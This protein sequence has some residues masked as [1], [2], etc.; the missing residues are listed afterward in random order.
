M[1][2][3]SELRSEILDGLGLDAAT[4]APFS[5]DLEQW[6]S[7]LAVDQPWQDEATNLE[8]RALFLRAS[9][10]IERVIRDRETVALGV[11]PPAWL[12]QLVAHWAASNTTVVTFNYDQLLERALIHL[13]IAH[14][15]VDLYRGPMALRGIPAGHSFGFPA[16]AGPVP[17]I[18][19]L[20]GST[21]WGYNPT[22][23]DA[24]IVVTDDS[25]HWAPTDADQDI[26]PRN[27]G[28]YDDLLPMIVPPMSSK[29]DYY[30][31]AILRSQ[32]RRA[33][34]ELQKAT[35]VTIIGYS[36]PKTDY[37]SRLFIS[38]MPTTTPVTV[39]DHCS[40]MDSIIRGLLPGRPFTPMY[41]GPGAVE[42]Y[43][44]ENT[45]SMVQADIHYQGDGNVATISVGGKTMTESAPGA[46]HEAHA[47]LQR[48]L[49][50][51]IGIDDWMN[52]GSF[53]RVAGMCHWVGAQHLVYTFPEQ[54]GVYLSE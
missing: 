54:V 16:P 50:A 15:V 35:S 11:R 25:A 37:T 9:E 8:N 18:L 5:E 2:L 40:D 14:N 17:A 10:A 46:T 12:L 4:L 45:G 6:L 42:R 52:R 49:S 48:E 3:M 31:G 23:R 26:L 24:P 7:S 51:C 39:V 28:L 21:N 30:S 29:S 1:P 32:W 41:A 33:S 47:F 20:H 38:Q 13:G 34:I 53:Y 27:V 36:F 22:V 44:G 19:K 43:V